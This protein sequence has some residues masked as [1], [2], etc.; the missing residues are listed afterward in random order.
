M[1]LNRSYLYLLQ[2]TS[3][4]F[5]LECDTDTRNCLPDKL[6]LKGLK[7]LKNIQIVT[8]NKGQQYGL[9]YAHACHIYNKS[10][11]KPMIKAKEKTL[12]ETLYL[13]VPAV[14]T[15]YHC[16]LKKMLLKKLRYK[17]IVYSLFLL[18]MTVLSISD[19]H[20]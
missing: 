16:T 10:K 2:V 13:L 12:E 18:F 8:Y 19:V 4:F 9:C 14:P 1:L 6:C 3:T 11:G 7:S 5:L 15:L 17:R 20:L